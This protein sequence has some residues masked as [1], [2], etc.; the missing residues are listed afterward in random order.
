MTHTADPVRGEPLGRSRMGLAVAAPAAVAAFFIAAG[1]AE[2]PD[3]EQPV[4]A[5]SGALG[6]WAYLV[7]GVFAFFET[8]AFV[9]L[10][11][12]GETAVLAGGMVAHRGGVELVP[13]ILVVWLAA[14]AGDA[15]SFMIGRR[16]GRQFLASHGARLR[17]DAARL[18]R[19]DRFYA[20]HGAAAV[21]AGR[22]V[23]LARAVMPFL[24]GTSAMSA[25]RFV[26]CSVT[27]ALAWASLLTALGYAFSDSIAAAGDVVTRVALAAVL[28][29]A[30]FVV[31]RRWIRS[32]R[33][34]AR[35]G[36]R[37][38]PRTG[39]GELDRRTPPPRRGGGCAPAGRAV[40][41]VVNA[42]ASG[43]AKDPS[44]LLDEVTA[45]LRDQGSR[46]EAV[47]TQSEAELRTVLAAADGRRVVLVGGDGSLHAAANAAL[48][49]LPEL[50]LIP[51]GR[52]NNIARAVGIPIDIAGATR[53]TARAPAQP[54][55]ALHVQTP[56]RTLFALEAV[57][58]GFQADARSRYASDNSGDLRQGGLLLAS[59][60]ARYAPYRLGV[61]LDDRRI[62]VDAGAQLFLAN[63]PF[64]G[65]GFE[66]NPGGDPQDG[67]FEAVL[68]E[69]AT[70]RAL[71]AAL[72]AAHGGT[73]IGRPGVQRIA[74]QRAELTEALP[75]VAD[76]VALGTTT[77]TIAIAPAHL[78]LVRGA[79]GSCA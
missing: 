63:L 32:S 35:E 9:G 69:A 6:H 14:T 2:L 8:A 58:A 12:P 38:Q 42:H 10:A 20:R 59:A 75:L 55:D 3:L 23:G 39:V 31:V 18:A 57:S 56:Q 30:A 62:V 29:A 24:A 41:V 76:T 49:R 36:V 64:F 71:V 17:L 25:R 33:D 13:L 54:F 53:L 47:V 74:S 45:G 5:M 51:A 43:A 22:F 73:H 70:R 26:A 28:L 60:V 68:I 66:V 15:T 77:A 40:L 19:V 52:A 48:P 65:F 34:G 21:I 44:G 1:A 7:V 27:G 50:A 61:T 67:I 72:V 16:V 79:A 4:A 46:V 11:V 37:D 78:R